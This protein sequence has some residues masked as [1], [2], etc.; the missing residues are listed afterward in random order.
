MRVGVT[1][2]F[3]FS[4]FSGGGASAT[5]SIAELL[6]MMGHDVY[7]VNLNTTQEWWDDMT[8]M[9]SMFPSVQAD[10]I[11]E[12]F[13]I[14]FEVAN[15]VKDKE[16]RER[17]A[18]QCIWVIRKP[19]LLNDIEC[20]IFPVS[21]SKRNLEGIT[22]VWCLDQ[23]IFDDEMQYLET[24]TRVPVSKV[25]FVWSPAMIE[26]YRRQVGH[27]SW[28]QVAVGITQQLQ[29]V[30]PWSVHICETNNSA[31][32]SC[33]IPL[34]ALRELKL[35][36][37][38]HFINY[39]L[40]NAQPVENSEFFKQNVYAHCQ[41][42]DLSGEF[43]G[44]QRVVDWVVDPMSCILAHMRFR[45]IRPY[46][47]E[48]LWC[49]IPLVHNSPFIKDLAC[50]YENYYYEDNSIL[51]AT[52]AMTQLQRD[53]T[54]AKGMFQQGS[55]QA[56]QQKL[57]ETLTP[58]SP[59]VQEGWRKAIE[60]LT[61]PLTI[62]TP[63]VETKENDSVVRVLFT[64]FWDDFN[65]D[66]N[67]FLLILQ[68]GSKQLKPKPRIEGHTIQSLEGKTPDLHIFGPFGSQ[69]KQEAWSNVPKVH[70]TGENTPP[71][72]DSKVFLNL[73][74]PHADF[75]DERYIRLPLWFLEIDWFGVDTERIVNP[76]P[77]PLDRCT[78]IYPEEISAKD[79]FCA[80]V[81]TNPCNPVRNNAF[82]WL[83]QYKK[84]DSAGRLFNNIGDEIFAG[85]GGGG[86]EIKKH[87]FLKKYKFCIAYENASAQGYTTEK[88]LHAK[89][90]G[91]IPIYL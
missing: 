9:K 4:M 26:L 51:G 87:E 45:R 53:L 20:S 52:K 35:Q 84:V 28:I 56:L 18:K 62:P 15:T 10:A 64:D 77:L 6:K 85:L 83:N 17:I 65:P 40:H 5:L 61:P 12:P 91:C 39:K 71:V 44:R 55:Q 72:L 49:G 81:V 11:Q 29:K 89:V 27:P 50:G 38:F 80:F 33:T 8:M 79:R 48:A 43:L 1:A 86:G 68:E 31:S 54:V 60:A 57:L 70:F 66:Y 21:M 37:E 32:S 41:T 19:I 63:V 90:A 82:H 73:G 75:V 22:A 2:H 30:L 25:P 34:V 13:D 3:Q 7:L 88:L 24:L 58:A 23:E 47:L 59:R 16:M 69:W 14:L 74:Y 67:M 36:N 78:K 42:P 46:L 76:K